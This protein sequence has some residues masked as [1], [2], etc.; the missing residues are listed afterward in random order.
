M[1]EHLSLR[2]GDVVRSVEDKA[3]LGEGEDSPSATQS[4]Y[5]RRVSARE[6]E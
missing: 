1:H 5:S 4:Y 2:L 3:D 6:E